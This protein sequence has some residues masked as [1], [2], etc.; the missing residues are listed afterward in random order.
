MFC[1]HYCTI[2]AE[3][4]L[5]QEYIDDARFQSNIM[6]LDTSH[7]LPSVAL[8]NYFSITVPNESVQIHKNLLRQS[9]VS[10]R[11]Y[12]PGFKALFP[13]IKLKKKKK[14]HRCGD[15]DRL[16]ILLHD[17]EKVAIN[18]DK[19]TKFFVW[20]FWSF[21]FSLSVWHVYFSRQVIHTR[22]GLTSGN[23]I[24]YRLWIQG[25]CISKAGITVNDIA[26]TKSYHGTVTS[27]Y[28][29]L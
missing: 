20:S 18:H 1:L 2:S 5:T 9:S 29:L 13:D 3:C 4:K 22:L 7:Q 26:H 23:R 6:S 15:N 16:R 28:Y 21:G 17:F 12:V 14:N 11:N 24:R 19:R 10:R 27:R 25:N 8:I